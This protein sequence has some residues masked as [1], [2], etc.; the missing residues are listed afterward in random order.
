M[1]FKLKE[2]LKSNICRDIFVQNQRLLEEL[3]ELKTK[4]QLE[5]NLT[6]AYWKKRLK[7]R[8]FKQN[9]SHMNN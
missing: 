3:E 7:A 2:N 1:F 8:D 6:N 4:K 5:I 9:H